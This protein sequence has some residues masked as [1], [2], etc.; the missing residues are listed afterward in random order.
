MYFKTN[1]Q[2]KWQNMCHK[3]KQNKNCTKLS[4]NNMYKLIIYT[5]LTQQVSSK[6]YTHNSTQKSNKNTN[7]QNNAS[8][9][10]HE[11]LP[12]RYTNL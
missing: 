11:Y 2:I 5:T 9:Y 8:N 12:H 7:N 4:H 3:T 10:I 1:N 6:M